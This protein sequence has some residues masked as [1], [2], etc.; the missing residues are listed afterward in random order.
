MSRFLLMNLKQRIPISFIAASASLLFV[1]SAAGQVGGI[2]LPEAG[3]PSNGT[4][5]A[6]SAAVARDAETAYLNP[7]GMTRLDST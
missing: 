1:G 3:G 5:Q 6:G 7:A 2:F 4:A